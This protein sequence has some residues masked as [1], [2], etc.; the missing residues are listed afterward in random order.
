MNILD[1]ENSRVKLN[2]SLPVTF[3]YKKKLINLSSYLSKILETENSSIFHAYF[4]EYLD[5]YEKCVK[6][7]TPWF[8]PPELSENIIGQIESL[9]LGEYVPKLR[10]T[11]EDEKN[12]ILSDLKNLKKVLEGETYEAK[13][14]SFHFPVIDTNR[15]DENVIVLGI[16]ESVSAS[17]KQLK[18]SETNKFIVVPSEPVLEERIKKQIEDSW[19]VACNEV[20]KHIK[21]IGKH[22]E[23][24]ISFDNKE[25]YY[26]GNSL[27][28]ALTLT[29]IKELHAYYN[30]RY[31]INSRQSLAITG[32]VN[33]RGEIGEVSQKIIESKVEIIFYS[34]TELF[35]VPEKD[36]YTAK[37]KYNELAAKYPSKR[38]KII[39]AGDINDVINR[40]D[41][42]NIRKQNVIVKSSK[43]I[44][45]N[46]KISLLIAFLLSAFS[47]FLIGDL[48]ENPHSY[49]F[50][51]NYLYIK[52]KNGKLLW[53][54]TYFQIAEFTKN[55]DLQR[56]YIRILDTD[57]DGKN[58]ILLCCSAI[59]CQ[60]DSLDDGK[61]CCLDHHGNEKWK[62]SF[63]EEV[64]TNYGEFSKNYAISIIDTVSNY[65]QKELIVSATHSAYFPYAIFKIDIKSGK[66][67]PGELWHSG[68]FYSYL[69]K[70]IDNDGVPEL[71]A[72]GCNNGF[73][74]AVIVVIK[75][76]NLN[77]ILPSTPNY[78]IQ[79]KEIAK[80]EK[81]IILPKTDYNSLFT[82]LNLVRP[83]TGVTYKAKENRIEIITI[84]SRIE[85][86]LG[87]LYWFSNS[88]DKVEI[89][90]G[91]A[92]A[93]AR[94]QY[95]KKG[96]LPLPFSDSE[97]YR[98]ILKKQI[99]V[100]TLNDFT[101]DFSGL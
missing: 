46:W 5:L 21:K 45:R 75:I 38:L 61:I 6:V 51:G 42:V 26:E 71:I 96:T 48:D 62:Y 31:Q 84:E 69:I 20:K 11:F 44:I 53:S 92:Y 18:G 73:K 94:D 100:L 58:E 22:H 36:E 79:A 72:G 25:G 78:R 15:N 63:R 30:S 4:T 83:I 99:R 50:D 90:I 39:G 88:F 52:N 8:L 17:I 34:G 82:Q 93:F 43:D 49:S 54:K 37:Q 101:K 9:I 65:T 41:I 67:L 86:D 24:I 57:N 14:G 3:S 68:Q 85:I 95:V 66:K 1:I 29:F 55:L 81:Y 64:S 32:S 87:I 60:L 12:R 33:E 13:N 10:Y 76:N 23:V 56:N 27:G 40:R 2:Q 70:D 35:I 80:F 47:Y 28:I 74:K 7:Y 16:L 98:N 19:L 97:E 89:I 59:N 91:D 77:G